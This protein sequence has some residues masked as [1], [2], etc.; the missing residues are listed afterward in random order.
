M[1]R[2]QNNPLGGAVSAE[3]GG[4]RV[5]VDYLRRLESHMG[6]AV[7]IPCFRWRHS[8]Q[9]LRDGCPWRCVNDPPGP[10]AGASAPWLGHKGEVTFP[11]Y[12]WSC[13]QD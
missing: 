2:G 9:T 10:L 5:G 12:L 8:H 3:R 1:V 13:S 7:S 11:G 6:E 4:S